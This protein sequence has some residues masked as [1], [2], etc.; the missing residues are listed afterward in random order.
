M[1]WLGVALVFFFAGCGDDDPADPVVPVDD[2]ADV[3]TPDAGPEKVDEPDVGPK[4]PPT[5]TTGARAYIITKEDYPQDLGVGDFAGAREGD[6]VI[7]NDEV[8]FVIRGGPTGL[9]THGVSG[10]AIV[11]IGEPGDD[12]VQEIIPMAS[13][14]GTMSKNPAFEI[15]SNGADGPAE[16]RVS[17]DAAIA[18]L[19]AAHLPGSFV[20]GRMS[21]TYRLESG[22][23]R[24]EVT[25]SHPDAEEP[26]LV[27]DFIFMGGEL[28]LLLSE[29][30]GWMLS[31]GKNVSYGIVSEEPFQVLAL[32]GFTALLGPTL[33]PPVEWKRWI[34]VGDGSASSVLDQMLDIRMSPAGHVAGTVSVPGVAVA[35]YDVNDNL[36]SRFRTDDSGAFD[37]NLPAGVYN[38]I[39]EAPGRVPGAP[40]NIDVT[41]GA[42][43]TGL[44]VSAEPRAE[45]N[46]TL[47]TPMRISIQ[48]DGYDERVGL[49]PG[50]HVIPVPP[51]E[52]TVTATRGYEYEADQTTITLEP[53]GNAVWAPTVER[54]VDTTGW[55]AADFHLHSEWSADSSVPLRDRIISCA[56][57]GIEY[58]VATDHDVLTDYGPF[59]PEELKPYMQVATGVEVSTAQQGHIN[60]WPLSMDVDKPGRG[61]IAWYELEFPE[62]MEAVGSSI[63]GRVVQINHGR[64]ET[65][66][67]FDYL[68]YDPMSPDPAQLEMFT[69]TAMEII[70]SGGA[71]YD[72]L[73]ADWLS[74]IDAG[75]PI[76]GTGVSDS[77]SLGALCGSARTMVEAPDDNLPGTSPTVFDSGVLAGRTLATSG[78]FVTLAKAGAG[79]VHVR[80]QAPSWMP[81][82]RFTVWADGVLDGTHE[83][84]ESTD[85]V[86]VDDDVTLVNSGATWV[87][88]TVAAD[89]VPSPMLK[90]P[91]RA[92]TPPLQL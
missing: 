22:S 31:E 62:L 23:T 43:L 1:R 35:A 71:G 7:R 42:D 78:P 76:A 29:L 46:V 10:G 15:L 14:G 86:R 6:Y 9:F 24:L 25:L 67:T 30:D 54:V 64:T 45:L 55:V 52:Y 65:S 2:A 92:V 51:G 38:L 85:V 60:V 91:I 27:G 49:P 41:D 17:A 13:L 8:R 68:D 12:L 81:V 16:I 56:A 3:A 82:D 70:N 50:K 74:F 83:I 39:A 69:F 61:S 47:E 34:V 87:V 26:T 21:Q 90:K 4:V 80:I 32:G 75:L 79:Q 58:A 63:P 57:E 84:D 18:P 5:P 40:V 73:L 37:G 33:D 53:E 44:E 88:V 72:E 77:H 20:E 11:D 36:I 28:N 59:M 89:T 66:S 19:V 48:G